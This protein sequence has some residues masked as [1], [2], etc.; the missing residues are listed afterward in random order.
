METKAPAADGSAPASETDPPPADAPVVA[1]AVPVPHNP[2]DGSL[3][4]EVE[5]IDNWINS[6]PL[7]VA[8]LRGKVVLVD[9]WTYTCV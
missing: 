1:E 3:A 4:A 5:G 2:A 8:D 6:D 7:T 9:F